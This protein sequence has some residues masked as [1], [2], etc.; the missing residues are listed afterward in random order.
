MNQ[1]YYMVETRKGFLLYSEMDEYTESQASCGVLVCFTDI[2]QA[3]CN[4]KRIYERLKID[5][6]C[7]KNV[8]S[9][10]LNVTQNNLY[11]VNVHGIGT[12]YFQRIPMH[13][14]KNKYVGKTLDMPNKILNELV[15]L[16]FDFFEEACKNHKFFFIGSSL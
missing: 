1:V 8:N 9:Y 4:E 6:V 16:N 14:K 2:H 13:W 10:I 7:N 5:A 12:F 11:Y 3:K 15:P